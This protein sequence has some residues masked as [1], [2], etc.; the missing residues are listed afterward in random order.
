MTNQIFN[1]KVTSEQL[2][3]V[4]TAF[5]CK[6]VDKSETVA[7]NDGKSI[8]R[9]IKLAKMLIEKIQDDTPTA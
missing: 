8:D 3:Q 2:L 6:M 1:M 5:A 4:A 7:T 9:A